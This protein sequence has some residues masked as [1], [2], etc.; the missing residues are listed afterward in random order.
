MPDSIYLIVSS[1]NTAFGVGQLPPTRHGAYLVEARDSDET[2]D[3]MVN[4]TVTTD[5]IGCGL[6]VFDAAEGTKYRV[7]PSVELVQDEESGS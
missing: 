3:D 1:P 4:R 2:V 5:M 6:T 7:G